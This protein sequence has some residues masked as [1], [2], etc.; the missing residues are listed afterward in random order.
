MDTLWSCVITIIILCFIGVSVWLLWK[1]ASPSKKFKGGGI[2]MTGGDPFEP[3]VSN[4]N[5]LIADL[6]YKRYISDSMLKSDDPEQ[7][8]A[9]MAAPPN[10][11]REWY[12]KTTGHPVP[13]EEEFIAANEA[14]SVWRAHVEH[15]LGLNSVDPLNT[16]QTFVDS[17]FATENETIIYSALDSC[18]KS[19]YAHIW[20]RV[21]GSNE[22]INTAFNSL[23]GTDYLAR[24]FYIFH[25]STEELGVMALAADLINDEANAILTAFEYDDMLSYLYIVLL[26]IQ[27]PQMLTQDLL[28]WAAQQAQLEQ[29]QLE[30]LPQVYERAQALAKLTPQNTMNFMKNI[31]YCLLSL[32]QKFSTKEV[33]VELVRT[34]LTAAGTVYNVYHTADVVTSN[35]LYK[36]QSLERI[37]E[38]INDDAVGAAVREIADPILADT[39][40]IQSSGAITFGSPGTVDFD[41]IAKTIN[42]PGLTNTIFT[43]QIGALGQSIADGDANNTYLIASSLVEPYVPLPG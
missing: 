24:L 30:R 28:A 6:V 12:L 11:R 15:G 13:T 4:F 10:A 31:A 18:M 32:A 7:I 42:N 1:R 27:L 39:E 26:S 40:F 9:F 5:A 41:Y 22:H 16:M 35:P 37:F 29:A 14:I 25:K 2:K 38:F 19:P 20:A 34:S 36:W 3:L 43:A 23:I 17:A 33:P 21:N 8:K